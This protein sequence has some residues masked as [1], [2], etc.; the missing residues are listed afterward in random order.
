MYGALTNEVGYIPWLLGIYRLKTT[1]SPPGC[2]LGFGVFFNDKSLQPITWITRFED[3]VEINSLHVHAT[4]TTYYGC[5]IQTWCALSHCHSLEFPAVSKAMAT[6]KVSLWR[7]R[8]GSLVLGCCPSKLQC[9]QSNMESVHVTCQKVS[10]KYFCEQW[11]VH[12]ICEIKDPWKCSAGRY[13]HN[14]QCG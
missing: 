7:E 11:E 5:A 13:N 4:H 6:L 14:V 2:A 8:F 3:F 9:S 1:S 12:K 10:L